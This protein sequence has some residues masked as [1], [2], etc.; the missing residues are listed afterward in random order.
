MYPNRSEDSSSDGGSASTTYNNPLV[1]DRL[2]RADSLLQS[3]DQTQLQRPADDAVIAT[4]GGL[5]APIAQRG[6]RR[7]A[8]G[9]LDRQRSLRRVASEADL[10][11]AT[12]AAPV[13]HRHTVHPVATEPP[14]LTAEVARSR[15]ASRDFAFAGGI[16]PPRLQA[17][18]T[19]M[20]RTPSPS[21]YHS[22][23]LPSALPATS[24]TP[25][26]FNAPSIASHPPLSPDAYETAASIG[27]FTTTGSA[28]DTAS[29]FRTEYTARAPATSSAFATVTQGTGEAFTA[30]EHYSATVRNLPEGSSAG[31][32]RSV[33]ETASLVTSSATLRPDSS[34]KSFTTALP[35]SR[36][37]RISDD[38]KLSQRR[39]ATDD[40]RSEG[41]VS[42]TDYETAPPASTL[43]RSLA[44]A[45]TRPTSEYVTASVRTSFYDAS[46][47]GNETSRP[48][49]SYE[50]A[51]PPPISHSSASRA[52]SSTGPRSTP[53]PS[54][55]S[56]P[57]SAELSAAEDWE[58]GTQISDPDSDTE[59]LDKL[60]R[61]SSIGSK[62]PSYRTGPTSLYKTAPTASSYQSAQP[63]SSEGSHFTTA[64]TG[65]CTTKYLTASICTCQE[66]AS[67][68]SSI[69]RPTSLPSQSS[70]SRVAKE[71]S[72]VSTAKST[73]AS[74]PSKLR[75]VPVPTLNSVA[76]S[77]FGGGSGPEDG[78]QE[79]PSDSEDYGQPTAGGIISADV[80]KLLVCRA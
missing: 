72:V 80:N 3:A 21:D 12:E 65:S 44:T 43:S 60:E 18:F 32:T 66:T 15:P 20:Q 19:V 41:K 79:V 31:G 55:R 61:Q 2:S 58:N 14:P 30:S 4:S 71:Q 33:Y 10:E 48:A 17:P 70:V 7:L 51:P 49:S 35:P 8:V 22:A 78:S 75:R 25:F 53:A 34:Q 26:A 74:T 45:R 39:D 40:A 63:P 24:H 38:E 54:W 57:Q 1:A 28:Y 27:A 62:Y 29:T 68:V 23:L 67:V 47:S 59:L 46:L 6:S 5:T 52:G 69:S 9:G 16:P 50:T 13:N 56:Y 36:A 77:V 42:S 64:H 76:S 11:L 73:K 37:S